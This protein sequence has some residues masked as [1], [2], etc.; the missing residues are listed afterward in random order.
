MKISII[1]NLQKWQK[2]WKAGKHQSN[3]VKPVNGHPKISEEYM[4]MKYGMFL[5]KEGKK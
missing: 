2:E 3:V 5:K 4:R 1:E